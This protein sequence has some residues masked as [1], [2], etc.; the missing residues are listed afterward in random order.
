[1][2]FDLR[3]VEAKPTDSNLVGHLVYNLLMELFADQSHLFP[4]EKIKKAAGD[5]LKPG[6]GV[7]SF[8]AFDSNEIVG[9][10]NLNECSAIYAGGKF[11][12]ITE[13]YVKPKF[14]KYRAIF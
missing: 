6:S 1:M 12:E 3:I 9:M 11:G 2:N 14:L 8:L 4:M 5:L 13:M 7:W 10:I